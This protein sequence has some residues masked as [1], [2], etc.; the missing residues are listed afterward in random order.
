M[1]KKDR[2]YSIGV[3]LTTYNRPEYLKQTL[4]CLKES[5]IP[6]YTRIHII[7]DA[8]NNRFALKY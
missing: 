1:F 4:D 5:F 8:S 7:D 2:P 6:E 3:V